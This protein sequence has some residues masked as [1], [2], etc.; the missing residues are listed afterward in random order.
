MPAVECKL[1]T[2]IDQPISE[3]SNAY[4]EMD[5]SVGFV[6]IDGQGASINRAWVNHVDEVH[7]ETMNGET[8]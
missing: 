4:F 7:M 6:P 8:Q 3:G 2:A 5:H 1:L